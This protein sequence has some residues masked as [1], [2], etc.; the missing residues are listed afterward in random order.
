MFCFVCRCCFVDVWIV[1]AHTRLPLTKKHKKTQ[2]NTQEGA[3]ALGP[4]TPEAYTPFGGGPRT[5][6][7]WRFAVQEA[8]IALV[9]L[10]QHYTF[11]LA[12]GQVP[13]QLQQNLTLA[14]K[15]GLWVTPIV[16]G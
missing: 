3:A 15:G 2:K 11:E 4:R 12:P 13:L 16:R 8:K 1:F 7:G 6:I 14:P 9:R 10:Y 5:C